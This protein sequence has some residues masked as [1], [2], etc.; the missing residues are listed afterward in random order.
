[1]S[2]S[3]ERI[4]TFF[5]LL[6]LVAS[7]T[8]QASEEV[9]SASVEEALA[10]E[11]ADGK[12]PYRRLSTYGF[13]TGEMAS[14]SPNDHILPYQPASS[15]FTDYALK[16]RFLS[17]PVGSQASLAGEELNLPQGTILIKNFYYPTDFRK[18][19]IFIE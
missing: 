12:F 6:G 16:S 9:S 18:P 10:P 17:L 2:G 3:A 1:M 7:C 5:L 15:L 8:P 4:F 13:F 11:E 19:E 14:L